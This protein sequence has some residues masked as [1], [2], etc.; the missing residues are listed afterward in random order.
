MHNPA[1]LHTSPTLHPAAG[2]AQA[3]A[4]VGQHPVDRGG[5]DPK[6]F[7]LTS[8]LTCSSPARSNA[9]TISAMIGARRLLAGPFRTAQITFN[10]SRTS[11]P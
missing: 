1:R 11:W 3:I 10:G 4:F 2:S 8:G 7:L 6:Q 5:R 9:S